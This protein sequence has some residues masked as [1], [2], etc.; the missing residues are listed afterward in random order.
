MELVKIFLK[1][2]LPVL[3]K[4]IV[5]ES[6]LWLKVEVIDQTL[7]CQADFFYIIDSASF[8]TVYFYDQSSPANNIFYWSWD[9]GDGNFSSEQNPAHTYNAPGTFE[10]CLE[11]MSFDGIDTCSSIF[12]QDVMVGS[13]TNCQADFSYYSFPANDLLI[14]FED[15][16]I[17]EGNI[18]E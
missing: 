18:S 13:T 9:F 4:E 3:L 6:C 16:S 12:C 14:Q 11:I 10:V 15:Q 1:H 8:N 17:P 2:N 7:N 5:L